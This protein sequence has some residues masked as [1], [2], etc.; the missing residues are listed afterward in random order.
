[1]G[2]L[3]SVLDQTILYVFSP[4]KIKS[5]R[6][7]NS[8]ALVLLLA[9]NTVTGYAK[10]FESNFHKTTYARHFTGRIGNYAITFDLNF[11]GDNSGD[12]HLTGTYLYNKYKTP[13]DLEG[14]INKATQKIS[15]QKLHGVTS[16]KFDLVLQKDVL[17]GSWQNDKH[18]LPVNLEEN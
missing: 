4:T 13:I 17:T 15:L 10:E 9:L 16:E 6:L 12:S 7:I 5:M 18:A 8:S 14:D 2:L 3:V 1:M 11:P